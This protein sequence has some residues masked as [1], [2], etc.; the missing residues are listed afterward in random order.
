MTFSAFFV[1]PKEHFCSVVD[2][3]KNSDYFS[4]AKE[5]INV[6]WLTI[7]NL[8]LEGHTFTVLCDDEG[9][10]THDLYFSIL[11]GEAPL[12]AG[13]VIIMH[14]SPTDDEGNSILF[15][16]TPEEIDALERNIVLVTS[17]NGISNIAINNF[18][19]PEA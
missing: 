17:A 6:D 19:Y 9:L 15:S 14:E 2:L 18:K 7:V 5:I 8:E 3:P 1:N 12:I 11:D 16:L 10:L 4:K 13:N